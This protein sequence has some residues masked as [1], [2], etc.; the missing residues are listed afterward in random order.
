MTAGRPTKY[1]A[2][3]HPKLVEAYA[4]LGMTDVQI[5]EKFEISEKTLNT[6]KQKYPK[7][8]QSMQ[9]GK[10]KVDDQVEAALLKKALGFDDPDAVKIFQYN[11]GIIEAQYVRKVDPDYNSIRLWLLNRRPKKWRDKVHI[12]DDTDFSRQ[13]DKLDK[14][15]ESAL[16]EDDK[17]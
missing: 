14:I 10:E 5:A 3:F 12:E 11:G 8:L 17:K 9:A 7:F 16:K 1:N 13:K 6:W 4:R 2:T 15:R